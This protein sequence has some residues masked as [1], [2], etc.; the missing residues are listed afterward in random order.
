MKKREKKSDLRIPPLNQLENEL[1][2]EKSRQRY[3]RAIRSTA[4]TLIVVAAI[5]ILVATLWLP[6]LQIY[7]DSMTPTLSEGDIIFTVKHSDLEPGDV[8]AFYFNNKILVKRV[9]GKAGDWIDMDE[10]GTVYVNGEVLEEPY[11]K[12]KT[13]G[14]C[15]IK[16]PYQVPDSQF[17]VMGD[18]R[19]TSVDSR[20]TSIG[21]VAEEQIVGKISFCV[22]PIS[23]FG[24]I[25]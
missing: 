10:D 5:A 25:K 22:W 21:C 23:R 14:E 8:I 20:N 13:Y 11:V 24:K 15:D 6:V 16:L 12:E 3:S 9:I 19:S 2:W 17:F 7:G 1:K 4:G 18:H